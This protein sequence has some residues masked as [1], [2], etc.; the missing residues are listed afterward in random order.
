[1]GTETYVSKT[2][3]DWRRN[4]TAKECD[5]VGGEGGFKINISKANVGVEGFNVGG[6]GE[7]ENTIVTH[8]GGGLKPAIMNSIRVG[9]GTKPIRNPTM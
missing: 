8:H 6:E 9:E 7:F 2:H 4:K 1:M 3:V 5:R